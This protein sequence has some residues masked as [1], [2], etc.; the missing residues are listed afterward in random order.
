MKWHSALLGMIAVLLLAATPSAGQEDRDAAMRAAQ[1]GPVHKH[2]AKRIGE[3]TTTTKFFV[4]PGGAGQES[5]GTAKITG[6]L[7]GRFLLEENSGTFF[8]QP[9]TGLRL[10]GYNNGS[11]QYEAVW[12]YS[13][14]TGIMNLVGTSKDDGKT[15]NWTATY[16]DP[17]GAKQT[18][19]VVTRN[20]DD[21]HFVIELIVK[22]ADGSKGP[23]TMETTYSRKR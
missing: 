22:S 2:M 21:D 10:Y 11:K 16:D 12:T 4:Q 6:A 18:L 23:P 7:D 5:H 19:Y 15:I 14:S 17:K 20:I 1:P 3:Y 13:R 9:L 8:G